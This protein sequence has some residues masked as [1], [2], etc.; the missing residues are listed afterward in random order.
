[1][2]KKSTTNQ[3]VAVR[4]P[5]ALLKR[6]SRWSKSAGRMNQSDAIRALIDAGLEAK[7]AKETPAAPEWAARLE[8]LAA[9]LRTDAAGAVDYLAEVLAAPDAPALPEPRTPARK[10]RRNPLG[11]LRSF[12]LG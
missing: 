3:L 7:E 2:A 11:T 5:A 9:R 6:I 1:M 4:L 8:E 12:V 10:R